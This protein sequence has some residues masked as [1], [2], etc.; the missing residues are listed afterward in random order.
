VPDR[1]EV[2][3]EVNMKA[4]STSNNFGGFGILYYGGATTMIDELKAE[5]K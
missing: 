2:L 5:W 1:P 3:T 4:E